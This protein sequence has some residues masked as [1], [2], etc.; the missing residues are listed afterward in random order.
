MIKLTEEQTLFFEEL[1]SIQEFVVLNNLSKNKNI[2]NL[3]LEGV[4]L[5]ATYSTIAYVM[6]LLDGYT[7][8]NLQF[9]ITSKK[10]NKS[11]KESI[12]LHDTCVDFLKCRK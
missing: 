2:K 11:L 12:E 10:T 6:E 8:D 3:D 4:L 9:E 7:N 5:D 1:S